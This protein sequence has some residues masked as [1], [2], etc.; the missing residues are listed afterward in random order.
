MTPTLPNHENGNDN[1]ERQSNRN[2]EFVRS[3]RV[4]RGRK[5]KKENASKEERPRNDFLSHRNPAGLL[6]KAD[7]ANL[8]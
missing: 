3:T 1:D 7:P 5:A 4:R 8:A 2:Q 6:A